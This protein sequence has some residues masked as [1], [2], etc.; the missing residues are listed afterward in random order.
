MRSQRLRNWWENVQAS[1]WFL[2]SLCAVAAVVLAWAAPRIDAMW[3]VDRTSYRG[4]IF[5]GSADAARTVLSVISGSTITVISLLFSITIVAL[6]QASTQFSPRIMRN[7][8]RDR[9]NQIVL[10][11]YLATFLYSVLILGQ[12]RGD[13]NDDPAQTPLLAVSLAIGLVVVCLGLLV[14]YIHH[15]A[16]LFQA[17][18][19]IE[20]IHRDLRQHLDEFY[21]T[22]IGASVDDEPDNLELFRLRVAND[23]MVEV[24]AITAGYLRS[25]DDQV[26]VCALPESRWVIVPP[27]IGTYVSEGDV[28]A[29]VDGATEIDE[30]AIER[31][32]S[33]FVLDRERTLYQD[34]L[35]G[36]RQLVD[37]AVKA[38]S[39]SINDPTTAE[40]ALSCI[41]D[42]VTSL[43][44]RPFPSPVREVTQGADGDPVVLW[45]HRP[46]FEDVVNIAFSQIRR[47]GRD[48]V[49]VTLH[50]LKVL[51]STARTARGRR[52]Q[53][54]IRQVEDVDWYLEVGHFAPRD[55]EEL[56]ACV[57]ATRRVIAR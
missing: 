22:G 39:P 46:S 31:V 45:L 20:R 3:L 26:L 32:G 27:F 51:G 35:F 57:A 8:T 44:S 7:F 48:H 5:S 41:G 12:I 42:A 33:A 14:F 34:P 29:E 53:P 13:Q 40:H 56:Q 16:T 55:L 38:L 52:V 28:L 1:L 47:A 2:P 49:H 23:P 18:S 50:L 36:I 17:S 9:G 30:Q 15:A 43:V 25:V 19:I 37:V 10:A 24:R 4:F 6:Q 54:F 21:P 11:I